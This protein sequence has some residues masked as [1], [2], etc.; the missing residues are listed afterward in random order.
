LSLQE[1]VAAAVG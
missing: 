1:A